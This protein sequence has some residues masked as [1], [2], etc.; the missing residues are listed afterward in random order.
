M[1]ERKTQILV[2]G[3]GYSGM[4][5]T[6]RFAGKVRRQNVQITLVNAADTFVERVRLHEYAANQPIKRRPIV[7]MLR[8][9]GVR[10]VHGTVTAID[11]E[12]RQVSAQTPTGSQQLTYDYLVYALGSTTDREAVPGVCEYAYTL[13]PSG[14]LSA[15]ALRTRLG[16]LNKASGRLVVVGGG[17]TGIEAAAEF[18]DTYPDL[19]V[20]LITRGELAAFFGGKI[21]SH[22]VQSLKRLGVSIQERIT[23]ASVDANELVTQDGVTIPF[24]VCLWAGGFGVP[25]LAHESGLAV[26]Q[27]GQVLID[28]FMRSIS[29]PD[30]FA[31]GDCA[32]PLEEPGVP[33]R[34]AAFTAAILGAHTADCL[35]NTLKNRPL[36]PLS[37]AYVGQGIALGRHDAVGFNIYPYDKP[38]GPV[39]TGGLAVQLRMF[40]VKLL[41]TMPDLEQ[42]WP[43]FFFWMGKNRVKLAVGGHAPHPLKP[44]ELAVQHSEERV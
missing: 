13:T 23:V 25:P 35:A 41:A 14:P 19:R 33:V 7:D 5:F 15:E 3:A 26:N 12:R 10:F 1:S 17:A 40:F 30:I 16:A 11:P 32:C 42:R 20:S 9:T 2:L 8:G 29:H 37:F 38:Q 34:M 31:A 21:Q 28:R 4:I 22:I 36:K 18:A 6:T 24:D 27:R 43:G 39:F 44:S